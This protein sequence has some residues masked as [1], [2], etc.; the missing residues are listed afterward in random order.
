MEQDNLIGRTIDKYDIIDEIA[1]GGMATVY[2][3]R[4]Q[5]V[6]R[7]VAIKVIDA[8]YA[9]DPTLMQ[10]FRREVDLIAT[11]QHPHIL[12]S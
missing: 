2:K 1:R 8:E 7:T 5:T 9:K 3:A 12:L 11:L 4:Q 6:N 10:R